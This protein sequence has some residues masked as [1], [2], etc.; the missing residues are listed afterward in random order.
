MKGISPK[1]SVDKQDFFCGTKCGRIV[2]MWNIK[3]EYTKTK[4]I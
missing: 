1:N 3:K 2:E 4:F